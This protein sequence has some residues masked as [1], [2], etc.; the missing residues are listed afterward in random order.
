MTC[1]TAEG[2]KNLKSN[3]SNEMVSALGD[4]NFTHD[5]YREEL[6]NYY[7]ENFPLSSFIYTGAKHINKPLG[8][9]SLQPINPDGTTLE[10]YINGHTS[11]DPIQ[12]KH[13]ITI[14]LVTLNNE[15]SYYR[16]CVADEG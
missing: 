10:D 2:L 6:I 13:D 12:A 9:A 15:L 7:I 4:D 3:F 11:L 5:T 8:N 14:D 16:R 1:F